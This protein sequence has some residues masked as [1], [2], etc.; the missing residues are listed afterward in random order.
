MVTGISLNDVTSGSLSSEAAELLWKIAS[1][2]MTEDQKERAYSAAE[3][4]ASVCV[5]DCCISMPKTSPRL[6]LW[7]WLGLTS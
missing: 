2:D 4:A 3:K 1:S 5:S 7:Q 6:T